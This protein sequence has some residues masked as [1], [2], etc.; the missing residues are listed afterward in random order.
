LIIETFVDHIEMLLAAKGVGG[1][2]VSGVCQLCPSLH[3]TSRPYK[4]SD[5]SHLNFEFAF[6]KDTLENGRLEGGFYGVCGCGRPNAL[7]VVE[8][9]R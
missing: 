4:V 3:N 2:R 1:V 7:G 9:N 8:R 6:S 5:S